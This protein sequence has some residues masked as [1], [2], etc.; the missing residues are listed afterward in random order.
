MFKI[1]P[2]TQHRVIQKLAVAMKPTQEERDGYNRVRRFERR[3]DGLFKKVYALQQ[4]SN[5]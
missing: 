5:N 2:A 3:R 1:S 4:E